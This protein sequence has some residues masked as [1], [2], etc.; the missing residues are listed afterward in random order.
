MPKRR[1]RR[2]SLPPQVELT[3]G[4]VLRLVYEQNPKAF[5]G[6]PFLF[7]APNA[8]LMLPE[9]LKRKAEFEAKREPAQQ[10]KFDQVLG[11]LINLYLF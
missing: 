3:Y 6:N 4:D 11:E 9:L 10:A 1:N 7:P 2:F 8:P 5:Q